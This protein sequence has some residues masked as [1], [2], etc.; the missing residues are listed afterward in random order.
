[1]S[2]KFKRKGKSKFTM[3]EGYVRRSAAYKSLSPSDRC[4]YDELKWAFNGVNNGWI[5][6]SVRDLASAINVDKNAAARSLK[7]LESK[8]FISIATKGAFSVK[9]G[10]AS[11]WLLTEY[12]DDRN[13]SLPL[14]T[15]M[16]WR[17]EEKSTVPLEGRTVPLEGHWPIPKVRKCG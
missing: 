3:L 5:G 9:L 16:H 1:M 13:G 2:G 8:G 10:R 4:A 11:E 17:P 15:F 12:K 14:K 6:L 7:N